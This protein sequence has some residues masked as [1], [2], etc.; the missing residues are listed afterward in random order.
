MKQCVG[1]VGVDP[2]YAAIGM[3]LVLVDMD[4]G[5]PRLVWCATIRSGSDTDD[6]ERTVIDSMAQGFEKCWALLRGS[7]TE[8]RA[9]SVESTLGALVAAS[10]MRTSNAAALRS[11]LIEGA[12]LG[13]AADRCLPVYRPTPQQTREHLGLAKGATKKDVSSALGLLMPT[14]LRS[15]EHARDAAAIA[16]YGAVKHWDQL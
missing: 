6:R 16:Y 3:A 1:C 4:S 14:G 15:S 5:E 7:G 11:L 13:I 10:R 9:V 2:G 12:A 8:H